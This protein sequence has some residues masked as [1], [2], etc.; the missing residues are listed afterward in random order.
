MCNS[1]AL[2]ILIHSAQIIGKTR[3]I[4]FVER[5]LDFIQQTERRRIDLHNREINGNGNEC[6]FSAGKQFQI[7]DNLSG[8]L[9]GNIDA[10]I[11]DILRVAQGKRGCP[12]AKQFFENFCKVPVDFLE[13]LQ[14]N[15]P[16]FSH[17]GM[18]QPTQFIAGFFHI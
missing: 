18:D 2:G 11:E 4:D 8:R 12:A 13:P 16:H 14:K 3:N 5:R 6:F 15:I 1:D 17:Q 9:H 7:R 10:G